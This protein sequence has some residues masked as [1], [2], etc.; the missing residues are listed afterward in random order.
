MASAVRDL[1]SSDPAPH[2]GPQ[3]P[4]AR[5]ASRSRPERS[6][7]RSRRSGRRSSWPT[8]GFDHVF[9]VNTVAGAAKI[10]TVAALAR[11]RRRHG[12]HRRRRE[13][14]GPRRRGDAPPGATIGVLIE[15]DTGMDRGGVDTAGGG[16]GPCPGRRRHGRARPAR[17]DRLRRPL[18]ADPGA[19]SCAHKPARG[20]GRSSSRSPRPWSGTGS[21]CP[22]R[23]GRRDGHV[24]LDRRVPG[25]HRDPGRHV[26]RHGQLPRPDGRR[27]RARADRPER[28]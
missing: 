15:V 4:R 5:L 27:L 12:R 3:E 17:R 21:P 19:T 24:G 26:R 9:I 22:I 23:L 10:R 28:P 6:A 25:G 7:S 1:G 11:E 18:L 16:P 13:R 2:Q 14:G 20:D 8:S